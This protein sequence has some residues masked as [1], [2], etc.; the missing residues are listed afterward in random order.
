MLMSP[1]LIH[2][3]MDHSS[4]CPRLS[5]STSTVKTLAPT[6]CLHQQVPAHLQGGFSL[7]NT[8]PLRDQP[9]QLECREHCGPFCLRSDRLHSFPPG[10]NQ[11]P[12]PTPFRETR[13]CICHTHRFFGHGLHSFPNPQ[14]LKNYFQAGTC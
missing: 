12:S 8:C 14:P 5:L 11:P 4:T 13:L 7:L 9:C 6:I 1:T 3:H 10:L 2:H